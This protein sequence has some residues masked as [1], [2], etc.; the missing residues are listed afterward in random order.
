MRRIVSQGFRLYALITCRA[1]EPTYNKIYFA[2]SVYH[3]G[4]IVLAIGEHMAVTHN[5]ASEGSHD[6]CNALFEAVR[7]EIPDLEVKRAP[8]TCNLFQ[9]GG[10]QFAFIYHLK[11]ASKVKV[12]CLGEPADLQRAA[13]ATNIVVIS[14]PTPGASGTWQNRFQCS[15]DV[16]DIADIP[17]AAR[18][19]YAVAHKSPFAA[20]SANRIRKAPTS[21]TL[22]KSVSAD[23]FDEGSVLQTPVNRYER[24]R[25]ARDKCI[26]IYGL[27]CT[28]C[29]FDFK[30]AYGDTGVGLIHVHHIKA[31]S[32][33]QRG[34]N[35]SGNVKIPKVAK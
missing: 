20:K 11:I 12:Y 33:I 14:R 15:F 19:L 32:T 8:G 9:Q 16:S 29:G 3:A 25:K 28:I 1:L 4:N 30:A 6:L 7:R 10:N 23:L 5:E 24:N 34:Y 17:D 13:D 27:K 31:L 18:I 2:I 26:E 22:R 35:V 21:P